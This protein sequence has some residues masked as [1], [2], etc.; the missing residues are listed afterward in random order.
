MDPPFAGCCGP[1]FE[2]LWGFVWLWA[3]AGSDT[4]IL[5][6]GTADKTNSPVRGSEIPQ[7]KTGRIFKAKDMLVDTQHPMRKILHIGCWEPVWGARRG[8]K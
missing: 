7:L 1:L 3:A 6:A 4:W 8:R 2:A 5:G